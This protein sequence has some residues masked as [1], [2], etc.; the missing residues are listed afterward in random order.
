VKSTVVCK[1]ME[2]TSFLEVSVTS[3]LTVHHYVPEDSDQFCHS[4]ETLN[5]AYI[6]KNLL[7]L[8]LKGNC[9]N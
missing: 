2:V 5:F 6:P 8:G 3:H 1:K 4:M 7:K 9:L